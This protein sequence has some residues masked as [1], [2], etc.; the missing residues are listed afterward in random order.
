VAEKVD[1]CDHQGWTALHAAASA[2]SVS[3]CKLLCQDYHA[4]PSARTG[5]VEYTPLHLAAIEGHVDVIRYLLARAPMEALTVDAH[6]LKPVDLAYQAGHVRAAELLQDPVKAHQH[7]VDEWSG[8]LGEAGYEE[9][10]PCPEGW[11]PS[12]DL[13]PPELR[14]V[15]RDSLDIVC[16]IVDLD[17]RLIE[18]V[19]EVRGCGGGRVEAAPA[20]VYFAKS[21][22]QRKI[23]PVK[24]SVPRIRGKIWRNGHAYE[25]EIWTHGLA[26]QFRVTG[27]CERCPA[28]PE[29]PW[30]V[31]S[32]WSPPI[33]LL[34]A[35]SNS[36]RGNRF[37][38]ETFS[39]SRY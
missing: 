11:M 24:F 35:R 34:R 25:T 6:G 3:V 16:R 29:A 23:D 2:G 31:A 37:G 38:V 22:Q 27:R 30:Q 4:E 36:R 33:K 1:R 15:R 18:Y 20:R 9:Q 39:T 21:G 19:V 13:A 14:S 10:L 26:Y 7:L 12:L 28:L 5:V 32:E 17:Y 8:Y